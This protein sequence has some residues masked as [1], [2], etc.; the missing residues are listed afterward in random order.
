LPELALEGRVR[1]IKG[2]LSLPLL[3]REKGYRGVIL[4]F[5]KAREAAVAEGIEVFPVSSLGQ[6][7]SIRNGPLAL[8]PYDLGRPYEASKLSADLDVVD[9]RGQEAVKRAIT[10]ACAGSH[11]L[12]MIGPPGTC[13][14][15]DRRC[16]LVPSV[17]P[18]LA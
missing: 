12:L 2:G 1:K 16:Y 15:G 13:Q 6:A 17:L 14:P 11:N 18:C 7:S 9:V 3:A 10:I 4:P 8:E 5:E